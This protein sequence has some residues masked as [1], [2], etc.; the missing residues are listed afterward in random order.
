[1]E[2]KTCTACGVEKCVSEFYKLRRDSDALKAR[3]KRCSLAASSANQKAAYAKNPER[4]RAQAAAWAAAN[5]ERRLENKKRQYALNPEAKLAK[6]AAW[7]AANAD[8]KRE[9]QARWK[10]ANRIKV[11]VERSEYRASKLNATPGWADRSKIAEFY[12]AADFLG[13]VTGEW[14]HV[15][16]MVP[17]R[18]KLVCGLHA[19]QNLQV[20]PAK[21]NLRKHN[22]YWPD[23]P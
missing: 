14:H 16:H 11:A 12:F 6:N 1:M 3:C 2:L 15:D 21:E 17:L 19:E 13:M 9:Y 22:R 23:M 4:K 5:P 7:R 10:A 18:S 20:L 8:R